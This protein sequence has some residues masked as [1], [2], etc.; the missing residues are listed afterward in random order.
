[1]DVRLPGLARDVPSEEPRVLPLQELKALVVPAGN[2]VLPSQE[3][4]AFVDGGH[5]QATNPV[6]DR[7]IQPASLDLRLGTE[8]YRL[9]ASFLPGAKSTVQAKLDHLSMARIDLSRPTVFEK[10][11]VYLVRLVEQLRLPADFWAK[12]N[13]KSTTGRLDVF[14][15]LITDYGTEFE[16]VEKGYV[17]PL[18]AEVVPRT[19]SILVRDGLSLSQL[20]FIR[21]R[22]S[23]SDAHLERLH[24]EEGLV[25]VD[26]SERGEAVIRDGLKLSVSLRGERQ[27]DVVAYRGRRDAPLVDLRKRGHYD[28][29]QFW[30]FIRSCPGERLI[31]NP[32]DFYILGS[33][34]RVRVPPK[35]AAEM[36][37]FD[38]SVGEFRT[39]YAGF[40]DPGFGYGDKDITGTRAV[41]EVRA[42]DVPFAIE[43]GQMVG[44]LVYSHVLDIPD[45]IYGA[46]IGSAYQRQALAL[47]KQF[48]RDVPTA[49]E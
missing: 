27:T 30:D 14:T 22:S 15:R 11:C 3:I 10:G 31:L 34:Q 4:R 28:P 16:R 25:Y 40:F 49:S 35:Y 20:R 36:V 38:P 19:F 8:A 23:S 13:P 6:E 17:G 43:H 7:Q 5:V 41:M 26:D 42:H 9:Q 44:R 29:R 18:Y 39:H 32:G 12:A 33:C 48:R 21:G 46:A 24:K 45:R 37:P 47:S 1:M 2:G